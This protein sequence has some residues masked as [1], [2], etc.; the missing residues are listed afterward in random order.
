MN[1]RDF[2]AAS[3][4]IEEAG[5][6]YREYYGAD[7]MEWLTSVAGK[8]GTAAT[9]LPDAELGKVLRVAETILEKEP[10]GELANAVTTGFLEA[11]IHNVENDPERCTH[12][13]RLMPPRCLEFFRAYLNWES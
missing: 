7:A 2:E 13:A 6:K 8:Y 10:N 5:R 9:N 4:H 1:I 3:E 12:L 11:I